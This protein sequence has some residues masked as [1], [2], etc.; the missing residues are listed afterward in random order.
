MS[1]MDRII[2]SYI[3]RL[4]AEE[5]EK[6]IVKTMP[7]MFEDIKSDRLVELMGKTMPAVVRDAMCEMESGGVAQVVQEMVPA[8]VRNCFTRMSS[9]DRRKTLEMLGSELVKI[10]EEFI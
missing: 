10:E 8:L 9:E 5:K 1:L 2:S 3:G 7:L 4:S 6:I